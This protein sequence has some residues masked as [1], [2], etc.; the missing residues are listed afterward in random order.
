MGNNKRSRDLRR[1]KMPLT[2]QIPSF[3]A[4]N[5]LWRIASVRPVTCL[6]TA[7]RLSF[8]ARLCRNVRDLSKFCYQVVLK[9]SFQLFNYKSFI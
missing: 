3:K 8:F 7:E 4:E 6:Q 1:R 9:F 2:F 5:L